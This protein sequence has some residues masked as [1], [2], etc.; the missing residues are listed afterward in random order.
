MVNLAEMGEFDMSP[1]AQGEAP[2]LLGF[3]GEQILTSGLMSLLKP[4]SQNIYFLQGHGEP[5]PDIG[6]DLSTWI[7][8]IHRQNATCIPLSLSSIDN[9]PDDAAAVVIAAPKSDLDEREAAVLASWLRLKGKMLVLLDPDAS[10]PR[11]HA[12]L[13]A[14]GIRPQED[15]VLRLIKLP[16]AMGILRDV[17]AEVLKNAYSPAERSPSHLTRISLKKKKSRSARSLKP[18]RNSGVKPPMPQTK[19]KASA[20]T[21]AS[22]MAN[23]SSSRLWP[24]GTAWKMTA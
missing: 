4:G 3:R 1:L 23:P 16:F 6:G 7:D 2:I 9:V 11:L 13:A 10:T 12:L 19:R 14:N 15:R 17:T 24:I 8:A 20:M 21:M 5:S 22:T 18:P